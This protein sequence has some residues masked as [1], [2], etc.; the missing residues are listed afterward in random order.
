MLDAFRQKSDT[1]AP[2]ST[3]RMT[4]FALQN[5]QRGTTRQAAAQYRRKLD[6]HFLTDDA[7]R[8]QTLNFYTKSLSQRYHI[9]TMGVHRRE[10]NES[11]RYTRAHVFSVPARPISEGAVP[12]PIY[13]RPA[14][15]KQKKY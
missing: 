6:F 10:T 14:W 7:F 15:I 12:C 8:G 4:R 1:L 13:T 11:S 3:L 9:G 5:F 2:R